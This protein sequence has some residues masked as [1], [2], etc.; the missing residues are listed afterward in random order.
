MMY[1]VGLVIVLLATGLIAIGVLVG[2]SL[3]SARQSGWFSVLQAALQQYAYQRGLLPTYPISWLSDP[4]TWLPRE[5]PY[6]WCFLADHG[7]A[8][9]AIILGAAALAGGANRVR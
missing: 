6:H 7:L 8:R 2:I 5:S 4:M 3:S 1:L 9:P